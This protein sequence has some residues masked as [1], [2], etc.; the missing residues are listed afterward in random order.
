M[1]KHF[2]FGI[3]FS[4]LCVV[5]AA[6]YGFFTGNLAA[7]ASFAFIA[8]VLGVMEVSLS[9][10]NAVVNAK[11]LTGMDAVWRRRFLTWG[12][13]IAVIGMR[14]V[15]P[16]LIVMATAGLGFFSVV[17]LAFNDANAYSE[18]LEEAHV[19]ISAFGGSFLFLVFLHYFLDAG[20]DVHWLAPIE[21]RLAKLGHLDKIEVA[22][23][24]AALVG[25]VSFFVAP[26][27]K[28]EALT[29]GALG[30]LTYLVVKAFAGFFEPAEDADGE[31]A[32][33]ARAKSQAVMQTA[34][35]AGAMSFLYLEVLDASFSLDGV[36]GA[37]AISKEVVVIAAGLAIGAVFVR[38]MTLWLV[39]SGT[40]NE[41][42]FLEHGAHYGIG[43]LAVIMLLS[44]NRDV[45]IPELVTGLIGLAFIVLS[46][47]AS[48][49]L[50]R[51]ETRGVRGTD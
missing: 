4:V 15:F 25:L 32:E 3:I 51:R 38:S 12:I 46:V 42:R 33:Q 22:L 36:I 8:I 47:V 9:F 43:S 48:L 18:R 30:I 45:H 41:Y 29:S 49:A 31:E 5:G 26:A 40:L 1:F 21:R 37:F 10:D 27:E 34:T 19:M 14:F 16:I 11:V 28:L 6:A 17:E 2:G 44:M 24:L 35:R 23:T 7:A 39:D 13:A 20:K 50:N